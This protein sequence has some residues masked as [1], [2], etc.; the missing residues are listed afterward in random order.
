MK[1]SKSITGPDGTVWR[2]DIQ[3]PSSSNAMI[4]F[5]HPDGR[6]SRLDRYNWVLTNGPESRSVTARLQTDK[7]LDSLD[8]TAIARLFAR[9]MAV[10]RPDPLASR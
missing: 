10:S 5:R 8:Q 6:S 9:S 4:M 2:V 7:V 1:N 3:S